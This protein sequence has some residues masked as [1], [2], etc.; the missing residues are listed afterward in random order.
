MLES[1]SSTSSQENNAEQGTS[2]EKRQ[3]QPVEIE[4]SSDM[5]AKVPNLETS[6]TSGKLQE[7]KRRERLITIVAES[8]GV[9]AALITNESTFDSISVKSLAIVELNSKVEDAFGAELDDQFSTGTTVAGLLMM[10]G[11]G[12]HHSRIVMPLNVNCRHQGRVA[13][14]R[15][16]K[17]ADVTHS[18]HL[19]R[20]PASETLTS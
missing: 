11:Q 7:G 16:H 15:A 9:S 8:S 4:V 12:L 13:P 20:F 3:S 6:L 2:S 1:A 19:L 14:L 10:T 18:K 5:Q 17:R